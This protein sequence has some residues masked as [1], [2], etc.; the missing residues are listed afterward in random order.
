[1]GCKRDSS[2]QQA[3]GKFAGGFSQRY[4]RELKNLHGVLNTAEDMSAFIT[5]K[6]GIKK[7]LR[8]IVVWGIRNQGLVKGNAYRLPSL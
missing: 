2:D 3:P 1:M 6:A 4:S 8:H 7:I 5:D